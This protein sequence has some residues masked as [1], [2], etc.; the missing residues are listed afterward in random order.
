MRVVDARKEC[1]VLCVDDARV[2]A[3]PRQRVRIAADERDAISAN[4]D[5]LR[6]RLFR[7]CRKNFGV[8]ENGV[9]VHRMDVR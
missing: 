3:A 7:I 8:D 1:I 6:E 4:G 9:S 5:S 2:G